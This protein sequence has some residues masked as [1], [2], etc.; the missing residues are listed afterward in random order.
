MA[1]ARLTQAMSAVTAACLMVRREVYHQVGGLDA[2]LRVAFNDVDFCLRL[3]QHGY[4]NVWTPFAELYHHESA[5]RGHEDTVEKRTRFI[6]E[7]EF[8]KSRWGNQLEYDPAY[9]PNLTL[10]GAP[11]SLAFPPREWRQMSAKSVML[12]VEMPDSSRQIRTLAG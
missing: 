2:S 4:T 5:S 12:D 7:V 6:R 11:F 8:M 10:S 1:R 9:N 3:R